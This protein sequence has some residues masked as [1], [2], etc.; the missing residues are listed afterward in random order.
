MM[1]KLFVFPLVVVVALLVMSTNVPTS[2]AVTCNV[3]ELAPC[4]PAM[5]SPAQPS[6]DC[7]AKL[8]EQ[9]PC[10]C[11]YKKDPTLR[12][13]VDSPNARRVASTCGVA[14]PTC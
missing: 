1:N 6:G 11:Q 4:L 7:C 12:G 9:K 8:R 2:S 5:T 14:F 13:Y 10:L 3:L